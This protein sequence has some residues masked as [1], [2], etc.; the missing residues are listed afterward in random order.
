[1][2]P[3]CNY[4][5]M[6]LR[7]NGQTYAMRAL[8]I[9]VQIC[10]AVN[11]LFDL[12]WLLPLLISDIISYCQVFFLTNFAQ[13]RPVLLIF[14]NARAVV[15]NQSDF[16]TLL[17]F[18]TRRDSPSWANLSPAPLADQASTFVSLSRMVLGIFAQ[19]RPVLLVFDFSL[20]SQRSFSHERKTSYL[21]AHATCNLSFIMVL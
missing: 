15:C 11:L 21:S 6:R 8:A 1:M 19:N 12:Q 10:M 7:Q 4:E 14:S 18:A 9:I 13:N 5:N 2:R 3:W 20:I 17:R 16:V